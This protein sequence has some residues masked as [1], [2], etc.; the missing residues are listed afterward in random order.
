MSR[1]RRKF[2]KDRQRAGINAANAE[3]VYKG[4]KKT[5]DDAVIR[6][7]FAAGAIKA[8]F[9]RE[10]NVSRMTVYRALENHPAPSESI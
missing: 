10:L 5:I 3:G 1:S 7:R 2:I 4:R 8:A 6:R 9:A